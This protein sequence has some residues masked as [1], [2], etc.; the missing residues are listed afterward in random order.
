M[1]HDVYNDRGALIGRVIDRGYRCDAFDDSDLGH[2]GVFEN[3]QAAVAAVAIA[4]VNS[5]L[6]RTRGQ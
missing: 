4:A 2:L 1:I 5:S 6:S 3:L